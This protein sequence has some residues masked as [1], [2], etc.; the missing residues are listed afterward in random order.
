MLVFVLQH[1]VM[2]GSPCSSTTAPLSF[3]YVQVLSPAK[4]IMEHH[5]GHC[6]VMVDRIFRVLL[7]SSRQPV[8]GLL[9]GHLQLYRAQQPHPPMY[10]RY[11]HVSRDGPFTAPQ[12]K[13]LQESISLSVF[14]IFSVL[15]LK[16]RLRLRDAMAFGLIFLGMWVVEM[17]IVICRCSKVCVFCF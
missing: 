13:V 14:A 4:G 6:L 1:R 15:V 3:L 16:E 7:A 17:C 5:A 11:G 2:V 12:L 10:L 8:C 9:T